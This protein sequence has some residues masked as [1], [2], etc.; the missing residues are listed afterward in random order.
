M[1]AINDLTRA[2]IKGYLEGFLDSVIESNKRRKGLKFDNPSAYLALKTTKPELKPF[3]AAMIPTEFMAFSGFERTFS[4]KLGTTFEECA[5][6]IAL[7]HH[8]EAHRAHIITGDASKHATTEVERQVLRF[9]QARNEADA[10]PSLDDM[11]GAVLNA[12]DEG[13]VWQRSTQTDLYIRTAENIEYFFEIKTPVPNKDIC[14]S[15]L[16]RILYIHLI[17]GLPRPQMLSYAAFAYNP[18]GNS[19]EDY[20]WSVA[21]MYLPF[22]QATLIGNEFW[23]IIGGETTYSELLEIY[24]EVGRDKSK[25]LIESLRAA[26]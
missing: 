10:P 9:H 4:T 5:R 7:D 1:V 2:K 20:R 8:P 17:R 22:E 3:H 25:Y 24:A 13:E 12:R 21:K 16:N 18:Y 14:Y 19:R 26:E 11:I 6:L 15:L 23:R